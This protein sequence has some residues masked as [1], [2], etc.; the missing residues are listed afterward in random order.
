[1]YHRFDKYNIIIQKYKFNIYFYSHEWKWIHLNSLNKI[2]YNIRITIPIHIICTILSS[3][4]VD[5]ID[6]LLRYLFSIRSL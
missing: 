2:T 6:I 4:A 1:M 5:F 3:I